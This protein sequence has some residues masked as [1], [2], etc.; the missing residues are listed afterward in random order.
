M[1]YNGCSGNKYSNM[2]KELVLRFYYLIFKALG[3]H[4]VA[5]QTTKRKH[6]HKQL[7]IH[8]SKDSNNSSQI[9]GDNAEPD[10]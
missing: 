10:K 5:S 3:L 2:Y 1:V 8:A 7:Q 6:L 4:R 9:Q